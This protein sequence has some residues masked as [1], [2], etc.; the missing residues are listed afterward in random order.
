VL[1]M[2]TQGARGSWSTQR[3][4]KNQSCL[5]VPRVSFSEARCTRVRVSGE[6]S[7]SLWCEVSGEL[8]LPAL[9]YQGSLAHHHPDARWSS[10]D[11]CNTHGEFARTALVAGSAASASALLRAPP[12]EGRAL[13]V[14]PP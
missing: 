13:R 4:S 6:L 3:S 11:Y 14:D 5:W 9:T 10:V 12:D 8:L 1:G 7:L 2:V